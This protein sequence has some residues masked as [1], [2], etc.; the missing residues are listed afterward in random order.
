MAAMTRWAVFAGIIPALIYLGLTLAFR[1]DL[2][3]FRTVFGQ[4]GWLIPALVVGGVVLLIGG[5]LSLFAGRTQQGMLALLAMVIT[6]A[7]VAGPVQMRRQ[8][9]QVPPI[10]DISTDVIDPPQ[11][12]ATAPLRTEGMN[13]AAYDPAQSEAQLE[14]YPDIETLT[15]DLP[16]AEALAIAE[17]ALRQAGVRIV[18]TD[19]QGGR[20]EGTATTRWFGFKDDVV[21][22]IRPQA[23]GGSLIDI[24]SKSRV[25]RSDVGANAAR[26]RDIRE[27][28][29]RLAEVD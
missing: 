13:P 26:I 15:V 5:A 3:G 28:I 9:A 4:L 17:R 11:F 1:V 22:R 21:V 12:V 19:E 27:A 29:L 2:I 25:G 23:S 7:M 6:F 10:H 16:P 14:A 20:I 24:R 8:A 18:E